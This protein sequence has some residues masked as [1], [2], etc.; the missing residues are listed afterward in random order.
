MASDHQT[1]LAREHADRIY[2]LRIRP[3]VLGTPE[4]VEHPTAVLV[5]GQP[6]AGVTYAAAQVRSN[7]A[8]TG[9]T[10][11]IAADQLREYHPL[12]RAQPRFVTPGPEVEADVQHWLFRL[13]EDAAARKA[14]L[15]IETDM[16]EPRRIVETAHQLRA[17]PHQVAVVALATDRDQSRQTTVTR[18]DLIHAVGASTAF[19]TTAQHNSAYERLRESLLAIEADHAV[20]RLQLVTSDGRQLY[21]NELIEGHWRRDPKA[22]AVLDDFRERRPTARELADSA[23]RWQTLAQRLAA[24]PDMPRDIASQ[25]IQWRNEA[26]ARAQADPDA[27]RRLTWGLE[28]EAFRT[29][30]RHHFLREFPQHAKAVERMDEAV[31][32]AETNFP[33]A[34]ERERFVQLT[35]QR[36]AER[37]AEGKSPGPSSARD[38]ERGART[39]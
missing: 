24:N 15:V 22:A 21:T 18:Y 5:G 17:T 14:N 39:R 11:L 23:L 35:R 12:W 32:Y 2:L 28:A 7:L 29:M 4:P 34:G 27:A 13:T 37:I 16:R 30:A 9:A 25:A 33:D 26:H 20:D 8:R 31:A 38:P 36:L 10:V 3:D 6:G 19:I 1:P